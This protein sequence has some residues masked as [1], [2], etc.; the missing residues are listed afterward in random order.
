VNTASPGILISTLGVV[1]VGFVAYRSIDKIS[2]YDAP[3]FSAATDPSIVNDQMEERMESSAF[4]KRMTDALK[5]L[6]SEGSG[7]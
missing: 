4:S 5:D 2:A 7:Q 1:L 6:K 3:V